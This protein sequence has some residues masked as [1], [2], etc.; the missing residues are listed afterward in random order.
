MQ[1]MITTVQENRVSSDKD[2]I[3]KKQEFV[4]SVAHV[5]QLQQH[6]I[7][8]KSCTKAFILQ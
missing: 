6:N 1:K 7:V 8:N 3:F 4:S 2:S 5:L